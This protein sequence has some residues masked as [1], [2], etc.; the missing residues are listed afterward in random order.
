M[1]TAAE[2]P[3]Q[4]QVHSNLILLLIP[5][6]A[7]ALG[8]NRARMRSTVCRERFPDR[9][10]VLRKLSFLASASIPFVAELG[11]DCFSFLGHHYSPV[12]R[13]RRGNRLS[14][15]IDKALGLGPF[16]DSGDGLRVPS[17]ATPPPGPFAVTTRDAFSSFGICVVS[18]RL[19]AV[20]KTPRK[21]VYLAFAPT[22]YKIDEESAS[23]E[24]RHR[25]REIALSLPGAAREWN[26]NCI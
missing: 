22:Q 13:P 15:R 23:F 6:I 21:F 26:P 20:I 25:A 12:V 19:S 18:A 5:A 16:R 4:P 10:L 7:L 17:L 11:L 8:H 9:S 2:W 1:A 3:I 24:N 14:P